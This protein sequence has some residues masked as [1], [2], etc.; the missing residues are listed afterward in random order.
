MS[1]HCVTASPSAASCVLPAAAIDDSL[2]VAVSVLQIK[3]NLLLGSASLKDT[4]EMQPIAMDSI[5][6]PVTVTTVASLVVFVLLVVAQRV[7]SK[8]QFSFKA[9]KW[10]HRGDACIDSNAKEEASLGDGKG[11]QCSSYTMFRE[12][13]KHPSANI[14]K[15]RLLDF[16]NHFP[17]GLQS[18]EAAHQI[19]R[20][21]DSIQEWMLSENS[22]IVDIDEKGMNNLAEG[23]EKYVVSRL[24]HKIFVMDGEPALEDEQMHKHI[25]GLNWVTFKHLGVPPIKPELLSLAI[26]ELQRIDGYKAPFDK[27]VCILNACR[28]INEVFKRTM[29]EAVDMGVSGPS[30]P[31]SADDFLPILIYTL[32]KANPRRLPSNSRF[33]ETFRQPSLL[34]AED[35][36]FFTALQSAIFFIKEINHEKLEVTSAEFDAFCAEALAGSDS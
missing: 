8:K 35:A 16:I 17:V 13:L 20:F 2:D 24:H 25:S 34:V 4:I 21:I 31:L 29:A 15:T 23:L 30:R 9:N 11:K 14:V 12:M 1:A 27:L 32:I 5:I 26:E 22:I 6:T 19:H 28:V 3:T 36:Y 33:V 7:H 18:D 10:V